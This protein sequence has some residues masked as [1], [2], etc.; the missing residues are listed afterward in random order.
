M[1]NSVMVKALEQ[2]SAGLMYQSET[3]SPWSVVSWPSAGELLTPEEIKKQGK[4][5]A[6]APVVEETLESFFAPLTEEKDWYG[7]G[8]KAMAAKYRSLLSVIKEQLATPKVVRVGERNVAIYIVGIA[9]EGGWAGLK[10]MAVE[11]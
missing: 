5:R 1:A 6:D 2:A 9:K 3:D 4:Q 7:G 10:T 8:G 11:T